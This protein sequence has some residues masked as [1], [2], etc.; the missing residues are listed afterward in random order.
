M[1]ADHLLAHIGQY[2][3]LKNKSGLLLLRKLRSA[4]AWGLPGGRIEEGES[5][6]QAL[7][8]EIKEETGLTITEPKPIA[9][10]LMREGSMMKYCVYFK[11]DVVD[12]ARMLFD[13]KTH[14]LK[15]VSCQAAANL[16]YVSSDMKD[17]IL[18]FL[19]ET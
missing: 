7:E 18:G 4:I 8:R 16:D 3:L 19:K 17:I 5:W 14:S 10:H 12:E 2:I 15:W 11:A 1:I 6:E 9:V 13:K